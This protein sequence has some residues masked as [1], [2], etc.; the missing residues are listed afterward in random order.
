MSAR[1]IVTGAYGK[2]GRE[3]LKAVHND[4]DLSLVGAVD[5]KSGD[6]AGEVI[7]I[8]KLGITI[9]SDLA[10]VIA[11]TKANVLIDFTRPETVM[12]NMRTAI[13]NGVYPVAGTTGFSS[14][15]LEEIR[16]LCA[17]H[18]VGAIIAPN[19]AIGAILMM[20]MA[21]EAAKYLPHVEIIEFHHDQKL[22]APSGT[23]L[24]TAELI[25]D[26]RSGRKQ[27][28]PDEFEKITGARGGD[29]DGMRIHS[30]RL[31]GYVAH[32]EVIFGGLGQTLVIRHDSISRESFMPGV[33]LAAKKAPYLKGLTFG[34]ENL[35]D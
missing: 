10:K 31:P 24:R 4:P 18:D 15:D 27:G 28:H 5:V 7:G 32:Q 13:I 3:V 11:T 1:V 23:A 20:K 33:V 14:G 22:D 21:V 26:V 25:K 6:D 8:G 19:F 17:K 35:L 29:Y 30:V 16:A 12:G 2:M 9:N 34:L